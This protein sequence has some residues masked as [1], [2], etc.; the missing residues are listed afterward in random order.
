MGDKSKI[1]WTDASW[2]P[3]VGCSRVSSGCERCYAERVSHRLA[4][5]PVTKATYQG[6]TVERGGRPVWS[7]V[8]RAVPER[9]DQPLRWKRPRRVFVNSMSDLFH[10][11]VPDEFIDQ[12]FAMMALCPHHQFQVLTK[13]PERMRDYIT[14]KYRSMLVDQRMAELRRDQPASPWSG[15]CTLPLPNVWLGVSVEDQKTADERIPLLLETPA[16]VRWVS[17]EPLLGPLDLARLETPEGAVAP[18]TGQWAI[19]GRGWSSRSGE[20][21]S[22]VVAGGESGPNARP[23]HPQWFRDLR[24]Q[25]AAAGVA[26]HFKQ[27]GEWLHCSQFADCPGPFTS[28]VPPGPLH[29]WN[30]KVSFDYSNRVGKARAG[31]LLDGVEHRE[32]P[33]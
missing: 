5:N 23:A 18:L 9:L 17:A 21:L 13:R 24:D 33:R 25:C 1:S 2:N 4:S 8:V 6:L 28:D 32:Y 19:E 15:G 14:A 26:F 30:P 29:D 20:R 11:Q 7:N 16:A 31:H 27:W 10:E 12:V 22:W 3:V